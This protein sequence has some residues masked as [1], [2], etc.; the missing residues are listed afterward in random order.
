MFGYS[1]VFILQEREVMEELFTGV[2]RFVKWL[3]I[4]FLKSI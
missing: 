1:T 2:S 4:T 3:K